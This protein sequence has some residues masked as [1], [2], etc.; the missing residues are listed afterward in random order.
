MQDFGCTGGSAHHF[1]LDEVTGHHDVFGYCK[2]CGMV[3]E[4]LVTLAE[5][6]IEQRKGRGREI[7]VNR[8]R[9]RFQRR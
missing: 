1:I 7:T 5:E 9:V 8:R 3:R 6:P 4:W 2:K